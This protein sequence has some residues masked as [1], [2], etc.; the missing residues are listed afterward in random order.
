MKSILFLSLS[1][2]PLFA[3]PS[4]S[5]RPSR[6]PIGKTIW[7]D[8]SM[9]IWGCGPSGQSISGQLGGQLRV[10]MYV[11]SFLLGLAVGHEPWP[12][13][14]SHSAFFPQS[15]FSHRWGGRGLSPHPA[16]S[17]HVL[18][19]GYTFSYLLAS[20]PG[21]PPAE[22][23]GSPDHSSFLSHFRSLEICLES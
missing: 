23:L 17:D 8:C 13:A 19:A 18:L 3:H 22:S 15:P 6:P 4:L 9:A 20:R 7:S 14:T 5:D 1:L 21:A 16:A 11:P 10:A 12:E 2:C